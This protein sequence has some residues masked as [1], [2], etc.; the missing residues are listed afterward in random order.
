ME[1]EEIKRTLEIKYKQ[2]EN[3]KNAKEKETNKWR[4]DYERLKFLK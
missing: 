3:Q 4:E 1:I 2:L